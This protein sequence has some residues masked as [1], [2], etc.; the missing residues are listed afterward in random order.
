ML[1]DNQ[2]H[3]YTMNLDF[4]LDE[5]LKFKQIISKDEQE[6]AERFVFDRDRNFFIVSRGQLR[7]ILGNYLHQ[8]PKSI[9][10]SYSTTGKPYIEES[11]LFFNVSHS[12][13]II[14]LGFVNKTAIGID[15]EYVRDIKDLK[16]MAERFF[17]EDEYKKICQL[18]KDLRQNLFFK[19]WTCK[20]AYLK[21]TGTGISGLEDMDFNIPSID[22]KFSFVDRHGKNWCCLIFRPD[23]EYA[24]AV[25]TEEKG[26]GLNYKFFPVNS[27]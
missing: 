18:K 24:G 15:I 19:Y 27:V 5:V 6:R 2:I 14:T 25:V 7:M 26:C 20:E 4:L 17:S 12:Q 11:S 10:F 22:K 9:K 13:D 1:P 21:A 8:E 23:D 3:I 16:E